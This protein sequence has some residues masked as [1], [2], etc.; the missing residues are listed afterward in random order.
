MNFIILP[1]I[2]GLSTY[3]ETSSTHLDFRG[4]PSPSPLPTE[5][6]PP[7]AWKQVLIYS[8]IF[9]CFFIVY[10]TVVTHLGRR[11]RAAAAER[12]Q[13]R[14]QQHEEY[15]RET[16]EF[17][18]IPTVAIPTSLPGISSASSIRMYR[19]MYVTE[20]KHKLKYLMEHL[21]I[22]QLTKEQVENNPICPICLDPFESSGE[23]TSATHADIEEGNG[24]FSN[25]VTAG[26][27]T[28]YMHRQCL[29]KWLVK[30]RALSCP[31]CRQPLLSM[32]Q[33]QEEDNERENCEQK[34]LSSRC[35]SSSTAGFTITSSS[36][37][38]SSTFFSE[39][40]NSRRESVA[41]SILQNPNPE[42]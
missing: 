7:F 40:S 30:D 15:M 36:S 14:R 6:D 9:F 22:V 29:Y 41:D 38:S 17:Q 21:L 34:G 5:E 39:A 11:A 31:V 12:R 42:T 1:T 33:K 3:V 20:F 37:L 23:E 35:A 16:S 24:H 8:T 26:V 32:I 10:F 27:C 18:S 13:R 28:H 25:E 4:S 19:M 2:Y